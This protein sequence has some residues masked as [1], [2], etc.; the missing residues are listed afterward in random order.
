MG[1]PLFTIVGYAEEPLL[2]QSPAPQ[3][4][5]IR[6][7]KQSRTVPERSRCGRRR[8][9]QA[10]RYAR[11]CTRL[12]AQ[13]KMAAV[14]IHDPFCDGKSQ[15]RPACSGIS[16]RV[17]AEKPLKHMRHI[18]LGNSNTAVLH[19]D[20]GRAVRTEQHAE[21][22]TLARFCILHRVIHKNAHRLLEQ[23]V[24]RVR[25]RRI[26]ALKLPDMLRMDHFVSQVEKI[27]DQLFRWVTEETFPE[28]V[29]VVIPYLWQKGT[30]LLPDQY[31]KKHQNNKER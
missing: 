2:R 28:P 3:L 26:D 30:A 21:A 15:P 19:L 18:L 4:P 22:N 5:I 13:F 8:F 23:R 12:A 17:C 10:D 29:E 6:F 27:A 24:I 16:R 31:K 1:R 20:A 9:G 14:S 11:S 7:S 25:L